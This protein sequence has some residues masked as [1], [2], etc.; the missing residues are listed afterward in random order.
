MNR[1]PPPNT[2]PSH[3]NPMTSNN[4][5]IMFPGGGIIGGENN[6]NNGGT[7]LPF[8]LESVNAMPVDQQAF[9]DLDV[10]AV[11]RHEL[12]QG[13]SLICRKKK[14][15]FFFVK[16]VWMIKEI[17]K[18]FF[19]VLISLIFFYIFFYFFIWL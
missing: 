7:S 12:A 14:N 16:D 18:I 9:A 8:D 5:Q 19:F 17:K 10:D 2:F 1:Q 4:G 6:N 11:L 3:I 15:F 13:D